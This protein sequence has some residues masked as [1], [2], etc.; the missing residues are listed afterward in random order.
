VKVLFDANTP[1][2]LARFLRGHEVRRAATLGWDTLT[3]GALLAVA[4]E[5]GFELLITCDQNLRYQQNFTGRTI[6]VLVLSTNRWPRLRS[7]A[8]RIAN[9]VDFMQRGQVVRFDLEG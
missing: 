9:A 2:P 3:N 8:A 7:Y 1:A 4:E 5:A 6:S